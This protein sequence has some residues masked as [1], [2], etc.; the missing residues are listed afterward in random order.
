MSSILTGTYGRHTCPCPGLSPL[1][2]HSL[3]KALKNNKVQNI[4]RVLLEN[5]NKRLHINILFLLII[6]IHQNLQAFWQSL[7]TRTDIFME[8]VHFIKT[9]RPAFLMNPASARQVP[10]SSQR[11]Q[12]GCQLVFIAFI[13]RPIMNSP[14]KLKHQINEHHNKKHS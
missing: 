4:A 14:S 12:S 7:V 9:Y 5:I 13:T 6:K 2:L 10:H 11:K 1:A 3:H 8:P